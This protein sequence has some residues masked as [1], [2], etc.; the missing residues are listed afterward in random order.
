MKDVL[1]KLTGWVRDAPTTNIR[2]LTTILL[3][4]GTAG[5]YFASTEWEP[6]LQWLSWLALMAGLDIVQ[7]ANSRGHRERMNGHFEEVSTE[8][9]ESG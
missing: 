1:K 5:K 3:A 4:V 8:E 6:S 2:I 7:K 9:E